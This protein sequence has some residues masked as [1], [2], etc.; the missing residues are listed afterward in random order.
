MILQGLNFHI[1]LT[2]VF[3]QPLAQDCRKDSRS[4]HI[5]V[6]EE[7]VGVGTTLVSSDC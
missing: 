3:W 6:T 4:F 7:L 5:S 2:P 1:S